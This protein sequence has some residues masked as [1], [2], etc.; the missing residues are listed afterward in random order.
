MTRLLPLFAQLPTE[1]QFR[2]PLDFAFQF[3]MAGGVLVVIFLFMR[4]LKGRDERDE[5]VVSKMAESQDK[6][7]TSLDGLKESVTR[8]DTHLRV[9]HPGSNS[10]ARV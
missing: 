9:S 8:L 2:N 3:G 6:L 1:P 7:S 4:Y 10:T 5:R